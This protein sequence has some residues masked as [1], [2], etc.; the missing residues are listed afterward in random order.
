MAGLAISDSFA[1]GELGI[2]LCT[3]RELIWLIQVSSA[4]EAILGDPSCSHDR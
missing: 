3:L 4:S 1:Y 2:G